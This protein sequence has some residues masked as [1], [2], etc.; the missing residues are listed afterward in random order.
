MCLTSCVSE[1]TRR[2]RMA[3]WRSRSSMSKTA[4]GGACVARA[5]SCSMRLAAR[6]G[7]FGDR[8]V[9]LSCG[10]GSGFELDEAEGTP[11]LQIHVLPNVDV[12]LQ[13][14]A[15]VFA[16]LTN[17]ITLVAVPGAALFD[18]VLRRSQI[19]QIAFL[20][21]ALAVDDVKLGFAER[22]RDLVLDHLHLRAVSHHRFTI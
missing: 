20:R 8:R 9:C 3:R 11:Q 4:S 17:A 7:R 2:R 15:R 1:R 19:E 12:V 5:A 14:L 16:T 22:R 13:E 10:I 21:N 18:D 6:A